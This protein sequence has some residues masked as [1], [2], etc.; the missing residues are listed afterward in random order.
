MKR[1]QASTGQGIAGHP[2]PAIL[3]DLIVY[4]SGACSLHYIKHV[5]KTVSKIRFLNKSYT[6]DDA[7]QQ[8]N[9]KYINSFQSMLL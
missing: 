1:K 3:A 5:S 6:D 9:L 8:N 7:A 4:N 2:L